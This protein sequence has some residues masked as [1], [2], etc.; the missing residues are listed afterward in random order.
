MKGE[1]FLNNKFGL[2]LDEL[3]FVKVNDF[4]NG[5]VMGLGAGIAYFGTAITIGFIAGLT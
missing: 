2:Q 4:S 3:E 1:I 5:I